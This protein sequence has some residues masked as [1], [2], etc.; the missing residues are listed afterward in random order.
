MATDRSRSCADSPS[1]YAPR[2]ARP[3]RDGPSA[4]PSSSA[5]STWLGSS[6]SA[7][8]RRYGHAGDADGIVR[9]TAGQELRIVIGRVPREALDRLTGKAATEQMLDALFGRFCIGK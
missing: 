2:A 8:A 9:E 4:E 3:S 5:R 7:A 1:R 6:D